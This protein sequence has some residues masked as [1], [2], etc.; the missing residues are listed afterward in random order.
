MVGIG[1]MVVFGLVLI[2]QVK[3]S[4]L[5]RTHADVVNGHGQDLA[6]GLDIF[7]ASPRVNKENVSRLKVESY[8]GE[9][10][11]DGRCLA[12]GENHSF[13]TRV[14]VLGHENNILLANNKA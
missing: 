12:V 14:I 10:F 6:G 2:I 11:S 5:A 3:D 9:N 1:I 4:E 8:R 13:E 7:A